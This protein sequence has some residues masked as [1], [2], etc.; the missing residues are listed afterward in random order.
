[1]DGKRGESGRAF[2]YSK[3]G[4]RKGALTFCE[5]RN[6]NDGNHLP[7]QITKRKDAEYMTNHKLICLYAF[8]FVFLFL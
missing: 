8:M 3:K 7:W 2:F 4:K 1:M 5:E 6:F